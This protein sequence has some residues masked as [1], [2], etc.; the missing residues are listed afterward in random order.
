MK[1]I[2]KN[3]VYDTATARLIGSYSS[4]YSDRLFGW[5]ED[6]YRKRT[7]EYFLYG[8]GGPGSKYARRIDS[9]N[10]SGGEE[11]RP[12]S[13]A[14]AVAWAE[15]Y[16][17]PDAYIEHFGPVEEDD[18]RSPVNLSLSA[19]V[20]ATLKRNASQ[21]GLSV[22]AYVE[23]LIIDSAI[24]ATLTRNASQAGLSVSDYVEQLIIEAA[25]DN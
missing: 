17:E 6:L 12:I 1:K 8:E 16:M 19:A 15:K 23:Q 25:S 22:S 9:S 14:D 21:S 2:I 24:A 4:D 5:S 13:Y 10:T 3:K 20:A 11:I 7:G 18:S